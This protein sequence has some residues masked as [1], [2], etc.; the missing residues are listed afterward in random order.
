MV[1]SSTERLDEDSPE[2]LCKLL[3]TIGKDIDQE[4]AKDHIAAYME[5]IRILSDDNKLSSRIRFALKD[6]LE[7]RQ[8]GWQERRKVDGPKKIADV[9]SDAARERSNANARPMQHSNRFDPPPPRQMAPQ[10][11]LRGPPP[12]S[13]P[14]P[15]ESFQPKT[16]QKEHERKDMSLGPGG[17][18]LR[19]GGAGGYRLA[20]QPRAAVAERTPLVLDKPSSV[21]PSQRPLTPPER[22]RDLPPLP[23]T[24]PPPP[25]PPQPR[26]S[27]MPIR[28]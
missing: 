3:A 17:N 11:S 19:P 13:R 12:F 15:T 1:Q 4:K 2:A 6:I 24:P 5:Q 20:N 27:R 25:Q 21:A 16:L 18:S 9:H 28:H 7:L 14:P 23:P 22:E 10:Q 26:I 8:S